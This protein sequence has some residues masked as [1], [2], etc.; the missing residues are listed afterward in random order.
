MKGRMV[1]VDLRG[2]R[3]QRGVSVGG[4][5]GGEIYCWREGRGNWCEIICEW[6]KIYGIG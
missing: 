4:G 6:M 1:T 5:K 2:P 3:E